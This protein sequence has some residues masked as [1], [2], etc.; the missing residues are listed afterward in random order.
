MAVR[1]GPRSTGGTDESRVHLK[2][3]L[4]LSVWILGALIFHRMGLMILARSS[5]T[6]AS[7]VAC[8]PYLLRSSKYRRDSALGCVLEASDKRRSLTDMLVW[9]SFVY[10]LPSVYG[11]YAHQYGIAALQLMTTI[12]STLFHLTRE[13][14]CFNLDNVFATSLLLTT[15]WAL[16][17][18]ATQGVWWYVAVVGL[19]GPFAIF[20]IVRCGMPG[21]VCRHP[22]GHGLCRMSNPEYDFF[23]MLWH[24][25][26]GLGTL[27]S[28][29]YFEVNFPAEEAGGGWFHYFP[30]IPVV[31]TVCLA[32]SA[33]INLYGNRVGMM[34][35]E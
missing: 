16:F 3:S 26:S 34:P 6:I 35:L 33:L 19:G 24:L 12:G 22:S 11:L 27:I 9:T 13:T 31:P 4:V 21:L 7:L 29:H 32:I 23:H 8:L 18:A 14:K 17:L 20:C 28:I 1:P 2:R 10:V 30:D 25:S 5:A 15:V